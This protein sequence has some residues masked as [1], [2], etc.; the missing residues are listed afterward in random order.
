MTQLYSVRSHVS[1]AMGDLHNLAELATWSARDLGASFILVNPLHATEPLPPVTDSPYLPVSRHYASPLYIRIEDIPEYARLNSIQRE[2]IQRFAR[3]LRERG[4]TADLLDRNAVWQAKR[5][6]LE[7]IYG[8]SRSEEREQA[9][10]D[11]LDREGEALER[12]ATWCAIAEEH[13]PDYRRWPEPL[14]DPTAEEV[15]VETRRRW[16]RVDFY[17]WTSGFSTANS[18]TP[19]PRHATP[20]WTWESCT[21]LRS[22]RRAAAQT[23][24]STAKCSSPGSTLAHPRT[25]STS[26]A[27]TGGKR[28]GIRCASPNRAT[29]PSSTSFGR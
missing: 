5:A 22:G 17:R 1:W 19:R 3:P 7:I 23:P 10:R 11:Y 9:F 27:R 8:V 26:R 14:R 20:E 6:A 4:R 13:G 28:P 2:T 24:G 15:R 29:F 16:R 18:P 12:Y 21:I 25:S